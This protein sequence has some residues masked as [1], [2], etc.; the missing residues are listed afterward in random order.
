MS[1]FKYILDAKG[2]PVVEPDLIKWCVWYNNADEER[3]V[4]REQVGKN[5]TIS[6][7]FLALDHSYGGGPPVLWETMVFG[8]PLHNEQ[9]RCGGSREQAEAMHA[10]MKLR[11]ELA[12]GLRAITSIPAE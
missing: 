5:C 10:A 8:G 12:Y 4:A 6:T 11:V 1:S 2:E 3:R 7:V 9:S